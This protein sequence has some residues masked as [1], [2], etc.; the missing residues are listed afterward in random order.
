MLGSDGLAWLEGGT[1]SSEGL[2][3]LP[4]DL[5]LDGMRD[6]LLCEKAPNSPRLSAPP[7]VQL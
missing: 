4:Q 6:D 3:L 1:S 2:N 7:E 5:E